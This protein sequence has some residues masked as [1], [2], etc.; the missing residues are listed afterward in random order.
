MSRLFRLS[1]AARKA[2]KAD[3]VRQIENYTDN[4]EVHTAVDEIRLYTECYIHSRFPMA[5]ESLRSALVEA[6]A[7]RLRRLFYQRSHRGHIELKAQSPQTG[8]LDFQLLK[9][10]ESALA[11]RFAPTVPSKPTTT[12]RLS[13]QAGPLRVPVTNAATARQTAVGA[14]HAKFSSEVS[15]PQSALANSSLSFPPILPTQECP[16]CGIIVEFTNKKLWE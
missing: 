5:P 7:L 6:N 3:Q 4:E 14:F 9:V 10:N 12:N 16:Y 13:G 1:N 15:G 11:I 8:P 2:A